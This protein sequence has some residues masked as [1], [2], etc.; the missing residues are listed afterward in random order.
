MSNVE[1]QRLFRER[2]P[3]YFNKYKAPLRASMKAA[4]AALVAEAVAQAAAAAA[5]AAMVVAP[6]ATVPLEPAAT[7]SD[8]GLAA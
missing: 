6:D 3:G 1:R 5:A 7:P 4:K 2:H 8:L